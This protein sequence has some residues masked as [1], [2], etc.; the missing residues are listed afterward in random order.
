M[1][2]DG[3]HHFLRKLEVVQHESAQFC[4]VQAKLQLFEFGEWTF[5]REWGSGKSV[6]TPT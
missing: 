6:S 4:V 5:N 1:A 3:F 2:L